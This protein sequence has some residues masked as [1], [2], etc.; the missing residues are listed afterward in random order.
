MRYHNNG[1]YGALSVVPSS[2]EAEAEG[3]SSQVAERGEAVLGEHEAHGTAWLRMLL[4]AARDLSNMG[5]SFGKQSKSPF[6]L[7]GWV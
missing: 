2:S 3:R 7:P 4:R 5:L 6:P 1:N